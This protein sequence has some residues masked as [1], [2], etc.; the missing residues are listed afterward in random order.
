[1]RR[2]LNQSKPRGRICGTPKTGVLGAVVPSTGT[3]GPAYIYPSLAHPGD[4]AVEVSGYITTWPT[5]GNLAAN[6]DT[7]FLFTGAPDGVYTF[8][9]QPAAFGVNVG[10]PKT[11]TLTVGNATL[12]SA[13]IGNVA[14]VGLNATITQNSTTTISANV[15][16][17]AVVG[18]TA[19]VTNTDGTAPVMVGGINVGSIT[20]TS[21]ATTWLPAVDNVAVAGYKVSSDGGG[22]YVDVGASLAYTFSALTPATTYGLRVLAYDAQGNQSAPISAS[23]M[24]STP[25]DANRPTQIGSL[26]HTETPMTITLDWSG[27]TAFDDVGVTGH[28]YRIGGTGPYTSATPTEEVLKLHVFTGLTPGTTYQLDERVTDAAQNKSIPLT[29][30]VTTPELIVPATSVTIELGNRVGAIWS[31]Y[32]NLDW[33]FFDQTQP[34]SLLAPTAKGS[35]ASTD[36]SGVLTLSIVGTALAVGAIGWL[37]VSNSNGDPTQSNQIAFTGPVVTS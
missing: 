20:S 31:N 14:V 32:T 7:S 9:F 17:V 4:D 25:A 24:T 37:I 34:H 6:E 35:G 10:S 3:S 36:S 22:T 28:E 19:N 13:I 8:Q 12:I 1:M 30:T 33:S 2:N 23:V 27:V 5:L 26:A 16:N 15:G 29:V 18:L 11:V 21:I